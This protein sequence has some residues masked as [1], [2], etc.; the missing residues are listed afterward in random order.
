MNKGQGGWFP[1]GFGDRWAF[2]LDSLI[3]SSRRNNKLISPYS[4]DTETS[5]LPVLRLQTHRMLF[6]M[7]VEDANLF[8]HTTLLSYVDLW[9]TLE[10]RK[11]FI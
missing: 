8:I 9:Q 3:M 2:R 1:V 5:D 6:T 11:G 4:L 10:Y 7:Q